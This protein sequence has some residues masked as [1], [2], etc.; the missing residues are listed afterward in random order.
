MRR[1]YR[2]RQSTLDLRRRIAALDGVDSVTILAPHR[3][4]IR[5]PA[6]IRV[7]LT[8]RWPGERVYTDFTLAEAR[9]WLAAEE[10]TR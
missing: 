9:A 1:A 8:R 10:A 6:G 5:T 4:I 3:G 7:Y 2:P